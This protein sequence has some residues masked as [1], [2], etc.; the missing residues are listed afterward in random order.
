MTRNYELTLVFSPVLDAPK[1]EE[2]QKKLLKQ[3]KAVNTEDLGSLD[4]AY[5]IKKQTRGY[6][7]RLKLEAEPEEVVRMKETLK[8][9]EGI[10]RYLIIKT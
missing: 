10:L 2:I 5:P 9:T 6:F 3:M 7:V 1:R 8:I 4:L